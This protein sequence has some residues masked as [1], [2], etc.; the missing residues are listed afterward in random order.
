GT[1]AAQKDANPQRAAVGF[2]EQF[3]QPPAEAIDDLVAAAGCGAVDVAFGPAKDVERVKVGGDLA[4]IVDRHEIAALGA[5]F[6]NMPPLNISGITDPRIFS[7]HTPRVNVPQGP[8]LVLF[9]AQVVDG[10]GCVRVVLGVSFEAGVQE[11]DIE[12]TRFG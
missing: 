12:Q 4:A 2:V 5:G 10:A 6:A 11:A 7:Q 9:R 3:L 8:V 1:R